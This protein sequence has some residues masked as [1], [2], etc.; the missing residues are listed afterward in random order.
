MS[1]LFTRKRISDSDMLKLPACCVPAGEADNLRKKRDAQLKW[2]REQGVRY[3]GNPPVFPDRR[4]PRP[5]AA[6]VCAVK[7]PIERPGDA[8][9]RDLASNG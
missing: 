9:V 2:M 3:L 8:I 7:A 1:S 5:P 6:S 4:A